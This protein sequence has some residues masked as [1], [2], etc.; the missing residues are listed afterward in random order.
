MVDFA[1][2]CFIEVLFVN[3]LLQILKMLL[4][5]SKFSSGVFL[6]LI[7]STRIAIEA[8]LEKGYSE[9]I[10]NPGHSVLSTLDALWWILIIW[11]KYDDNVNYQLSGRTV[12]KQS[13][14]YFSN[15][16][17]SKMSLKR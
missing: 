8:M 4:K 14:F 16:V 13:L 10:S 2:L 9:E 11:N 15:Y 1:S 6:E 5:N 17:Y 7:T 12:I 3:Q